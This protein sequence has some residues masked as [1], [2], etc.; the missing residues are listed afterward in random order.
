[1]GRGENVGTGGEGWE[2]GYGWGG[3]RTW[4]RMGR[5]ENVGTDG[6]GW[7]RGDGWGGVRT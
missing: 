3:V 5:G 6:E 7:E 4:V 2:R 1:M